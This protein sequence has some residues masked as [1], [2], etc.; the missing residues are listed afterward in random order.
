MPLLLLYSLQRHILS[1]K[2]CIICGF[3]F[4]YSNY[5]NEI[6]LYAVLLYTLCTIYIA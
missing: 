4:S 6:G 5:G 2:I 1:S 3:I